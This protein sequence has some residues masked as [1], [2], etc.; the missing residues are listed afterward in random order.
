MSEVR[1]NTAYIQVL[2][3]G[4]SEAEVRVN[5]AYIQALVDIIHRRIHTVID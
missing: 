4:T 1:V 3:E 5:S 2:T